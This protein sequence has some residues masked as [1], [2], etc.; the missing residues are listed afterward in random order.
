MN[1]SQ[2]SPPKTTTEAIG[3]DT[4][5]IKVAFQRDGGTRFSDAPLPGPAGRRPCFALAAIFPEPATT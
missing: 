2:P 4:R 1:E 3:Q 5:T